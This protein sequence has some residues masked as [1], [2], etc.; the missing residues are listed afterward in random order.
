MTTRE[1]ELT[2][3]LN[4][5]WDAAST[6][7]TIFSTDDPASVRLSDALDRTIHLLPRET[8]KDSTSERRHDVIDT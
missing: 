1:H 8:P 5:V 2:T 6:L 7:L 3:A 4:E